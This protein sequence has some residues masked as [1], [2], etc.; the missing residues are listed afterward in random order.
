MFSTILA[1]YCLDCW[2][3]RNETLHGKELETSRKKQLDA[4]RKQI[5]TAYKQKESMRGRPNFKIFEMP[6]HKRLMMGIQSSKIWI[7]MAEEAIRL[8]RENATMNTLDRWLNP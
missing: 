3:L 7:G 8:H 6:L 2:Q 4:I 1:E 5:K